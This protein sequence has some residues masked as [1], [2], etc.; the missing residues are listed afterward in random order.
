MNK[1]CYVLRLSV[2]C[3]L[4]SD[5]VNSAVNIIFYVIAEVYANGCKPLCYVYDKIELLVFAIFVLLL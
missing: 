4:L 5:L 1:L 3:S 2:L